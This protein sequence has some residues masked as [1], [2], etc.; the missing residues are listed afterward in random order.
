MGETEAMAPDYTREAMQLRLT[1]E[2]RMLVHA[3][4]RFVQD[5][6]VPLERDLD[7]DAY[8]LPREH[9]DRLVHMT[10]AMGLYQMGLPKEYDGAEVDVITRVL[11][12]E[13]M[14][15]HRAGLYHPCYDV[16]G[17]DPPA[18]LYFGTERQK[19]EYL[20]PVIRGE[21]RWFLGLTEPSGGSDPARAIQTRAVKDG[22]DWVING[23]KMFSSWADR[24]DF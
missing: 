2:Q 24:A 4:R 7:P 14:A 1:D 9:H 18:H 20:W 21:K 10:K 11:L 16:F 17:E 15:Q 5:E 13:E 6:I 12:T 23:S 22:D 19:E 8:E 3:V